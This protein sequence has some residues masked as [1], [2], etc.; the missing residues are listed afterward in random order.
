MKSVIFNTEDVKAISDGRKTQFR[1]VV[2]LPDCKWSDGHKTKVEIIN[3]FIEDYFFRIEPKKKFQL[4]GLGDIEDWHEEDLIEKFS[5]HK[6]SNILYVKETWR[7]GYWDDNGR[8]AIDFKF[9]KDKSLKFPKSEFFNNLIKKSCD[10]LKSKNILCDEYGDYKWEKY[11]SPLSWKSPIHMPKELSR[12]FL[13]VTN[14]RVE[15]LQD[16]AH[17][18]MI[19]E[20]F[21]YDN[22]FKIA[23]GKELARWWINRWNSTAK[24]S[25][26]WEDNPYV[27]AY[28]FE[29]VKIKG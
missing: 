5:K 26:K 9:G 29:I 7:L 15:R 12:I 16:I 27:F 2:K 4:S 28:D 10:E 11:K 18:D 1:K 6:V 17:I 19:K 21:K 13:K 24:D 20:G 25:Y 22:D 23:S 8:V 3:D 14:V